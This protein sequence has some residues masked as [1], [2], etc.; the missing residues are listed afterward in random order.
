MQALCQ[1]LRDALYKLEPSWTVDD[2]LRY[3]RN[4]YEKHIVRNVNESVTLGYTKAPC[5]LHVVRCTA[6]QLSTSAGQAAQLYLMERLLDA[7]ADSHLCDSGGNNAL[8]YVRS[9]PVMNKLIDLKINVTGVDYDTDYNDKVHS[10]P[11]I[12][13]ASGYR[14]G[15]F[16]NKQLLLQCLLDAKADIFTENINGQS[17]L[18]GCLPDCMATIYKAAHVQLFPLLIAHLSRDTIGIVLSFLCS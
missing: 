13:I 17:A 14:C 8:Q 7:K 18:N 12:S 6:P 4:R 15:P 1:D 5:F 16:V 11:I 9:L 3:V 10:T 2:T